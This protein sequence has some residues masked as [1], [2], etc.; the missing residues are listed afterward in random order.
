VADENISAMFRI[1]KGVARIFE[2]AV[3]LRGST[4]SSRSQTGR[5]A[6]APFFP[7]LLCATQLQEAA[8]D[9]KYRPHQAHVYTSN[10][11]LLKQTKFSM[12]EKEIYFQIIKCISN[13]EM[14]NADFS[15]PKY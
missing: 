4:W 1:T 8:I 12:R 11:L 3:E 15:G 2:R 10:W 6:A 5:I 9:A 7:I 14:K 13:R